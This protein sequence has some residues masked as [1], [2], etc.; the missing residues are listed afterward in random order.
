MGFSD[1]AT[2]ADIVEFTGIAEASLPSNVEV[3]ISR[4]SDII[5]MRTLNNINLNVPAHVDV[6]KKAVCAQV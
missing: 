1:Y 6:L 4:A 2:K 5:T 3:L